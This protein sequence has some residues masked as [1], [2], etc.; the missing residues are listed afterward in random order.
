MS[1]TVFARDLNLTVGYVS[2]QEH[3]I[4]R[5][6]GAALALLMLPSAWESQRS[7][8]IGHVGR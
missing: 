3:G 1:L 4:K 7:R 2:K 6:I 8:D 5:P